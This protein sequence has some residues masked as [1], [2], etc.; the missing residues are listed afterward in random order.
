MTIKNGTAVDVSASNV[1]RTLGSHE[2]QSAET[3]QPPTKIPVAVD[4]RIA[5]SMATRL[6]QQTLEG[7]DPGRLDRILELKTAIQKHQYSVD[8]LPYQCFFI[9][10]FADLSTC[11]A[12][13]SGAVSP[14]NSSSMYLRNC[15]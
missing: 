8:P 2:V 10:G 6:V 3:L 13:A 15:V 9:K 11:R 1:D 14:A 4:D 12:L 5:L 7:T